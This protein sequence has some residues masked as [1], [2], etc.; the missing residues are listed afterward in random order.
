MSTTNPDTLAQ[1]LRARTAK[2][3][4]VYEGPKKVSDKKKA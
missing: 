4:K 2:A 3:K 1:L